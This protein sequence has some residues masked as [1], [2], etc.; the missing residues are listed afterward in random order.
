M[1]LGNARL[2]NQDIQIKRNYFV[3]VVDELITESLP[4]FEMFSTTTLE[5]SSSSKSQIELK[6]TYLGA[7]MN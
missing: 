3:W 5:M 7:S 2:S 1:R 6:F 4:L